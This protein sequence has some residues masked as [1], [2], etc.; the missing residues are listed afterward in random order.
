MV[1]RYVV[2]AEPLHSGTGKTVAFIRG[3]SIS[4]KMIER[5]PDD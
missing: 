3:A 4:T 2:A 5:L 1:V